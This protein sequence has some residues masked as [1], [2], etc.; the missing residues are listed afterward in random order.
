MEIARASNKEP[1]G[2]REIVTTSMPRPPLPYSDSPR[3]T[4]N[5][6]CVYLYNAQCE[7]V[8]T[9]TTRAAVAIALVVTL[10][11]ECTFAYNHAYITST[12]NTRVGLFCV[13]NYATQY[14]IIFYGYF[15]VAALIGSE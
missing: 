3:A 1:G 14:T 11:C 10:L 4:V 8:T 15:F 12:C 7:Q 13:L 6:M 5:L 2:K 9:T